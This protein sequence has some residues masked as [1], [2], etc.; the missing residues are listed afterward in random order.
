MVCVLADEALKDALYDSQ[1]LQ[2][3]ARI[4]LRAEVVPDAT[5][6]L[7]FRRLLETHD[8]CKGLFSAINTDLTGRGLLLREGTL[9]HTVVVTAPRCGGHHQ[10]LG[11]SLCGA[12]LSHPEEHIPAS[13]SAVSRVGEERAPTLHAL[14]SGQ[15]G[16]IGARRATA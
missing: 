16:E 4:D 5:T 14:W 1:S 9:V 8:L 3:F 11:A 6:L 15:R 10:D 13:Q 7:K 2:R 12:S